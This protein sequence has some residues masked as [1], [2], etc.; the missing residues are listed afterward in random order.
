M[1]RTYKHLG[2]RSA[3]TGGMGVEINHRVTS[4][5]AAYREHRRTF[6]A[7]PTIGLDVK[8]PAIATLLWS[9][10]LH[11]A[12]TWPR[13]TAGEYR[14]LHGAFLRVVHAIACTEVQ[15]YDDSRINFIALD[16]LQLPDLPDLLREARCRLV[17]RLLRVAPAYVRR[18]LDNE[19]GLRSLLIDDFEWLVSRVNKLASFG[20]DFPPAANSP[21]WINLA[22]SNPKAWQTYVADGHIAAVSGVHARSSE[23]PAPPAP[24]LD[25][26]SAHICYDCGQSFLKMRALLQHARVMHG[27]KSSCYTAM[28]GT[29]CLR[30]LKE[31]HTMQRVLTHLRTTKCGPLVAHNVPPVP[32]D[33]HAS[34]QAASRVETRRQRQGHLVPATMLPPRR[35]CG[36]LPR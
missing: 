18:L 36:P 27:A 22:R 26:V 34:L 30:C 6:W 21:E 24:V 1:A 19:G 33:A 11:N 31:F 15:E 25:K 9:R 20:R 32:G 7:D 13:L 8:R 10:L 3:A 17:P 5:W 28:H 29:S 35:L 14:R 16:K 2:A 12:G 4:M 23:P